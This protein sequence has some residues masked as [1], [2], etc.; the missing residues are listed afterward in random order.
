[1]MGCRL[2]VDFRALFLRLADKFDRLR[3]ADVLNHDLRTRFQRNRQIAAHHVDLRLPVRTADAEIFAR[4]SGIDSIILNICRVFLMEADGFVHPCRFLHRF[5][6]DFGI[7]Q[8]LAVIRKADRASLCQRFHIR[9]LVP[10][11]V[12]CHVRAGIDMDAGLCAFFQNIGKRFLLI[13]M[14]IRIRH[15]HNTRHTASRR[16]HRAGQDIFL[17]FCTRITEMHM[18]IHQPRRCNQA[19]R[20]Q[21]AK[22]V[23]FFF[24]NLCRVDR[25]CLCDFCNPVLTDQDIPQAIRLRSRID[26]A[27]ILN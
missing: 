20:I 26:H 17:I 3:R 8:G 12:H 18:G 6:R 14:G 13:H 16:R 5:S 22:L 7:Q 23:L 2:C 4:L 21:D 15:Q 25:S 24:C 27:A 9:Q 11:H 10:L 19:I 1:M